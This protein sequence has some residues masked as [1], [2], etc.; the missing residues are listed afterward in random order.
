MRVQELLEV[1][2]LPIIY[3]IIQKKLAAGVVI[4]LD[5]SSENYRYQVTK[6]EFQPEDDDYN[7]RIWLYW[8]CTNLSGRVA[9]YPDDLSFSVPD[10]D[11]WSLTKQG[12]NLVLHT[13]RT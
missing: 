1:D 6:V 10:L 4:L 5:H 9:P 13:S 2:D 12:D 7:D 3:D 8:T 11:D